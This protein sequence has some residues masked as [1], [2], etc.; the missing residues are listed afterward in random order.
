MRA[1]LSVVARDVVEGT[2][3]G[4]GTK[5]ETTSERETLTSANSPGVKASQGGE[6][7]GSPIAY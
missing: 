5:E 3:R 2:G 4:G 6:R 1:A 7:L